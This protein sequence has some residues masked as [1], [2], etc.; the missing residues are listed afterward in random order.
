MSL[1]M[2]GSDPS[3][4]STRVLARWFIMRSGDRAASQK[5]PPLLNLFTLPPCL[6][7]LMLS[8]SLGCQ[9][10]SNL[11]TKVLLS[12]GFQASVLAANAHI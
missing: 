2:R 12:K 5:E 1:F 11:Q 10:I 6:L 4:G 3:D 7:L 9:L 8:A